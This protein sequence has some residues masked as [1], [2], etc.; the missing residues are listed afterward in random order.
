MGDRIS[1]I[2]TLSPEL[3]ATYHRLT[4]NDEAEKRWDLSRRQHVCDCRGK[5]C[6]LRPRSDN[7]RGQVP[8]TIVF[9]GH[10]YAT[11]E[12]QGCEDV[13]QRY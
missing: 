1:I 12:A 2:V 5:H 7:E 6:K 11:P 13:H 3:I 10:A 9:G 8:E 4:T